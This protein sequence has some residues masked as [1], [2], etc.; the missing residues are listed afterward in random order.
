[1]GRNGRLH[2]EKEMKDN[3]L[4]ISFDIGGVLSKYPDKFRPLVNAL[5]SCPAVEVFVITDMHDHKQSVTFVQGNE[6]NI[7]A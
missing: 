6:Y 4:R 5:V 2:S 3:K 1:M 7:P